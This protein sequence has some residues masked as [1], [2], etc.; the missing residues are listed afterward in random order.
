M[1]RKPDPRGLGHDAG[2]A[3][4][5]LPGSITVAG[6]GLTCEQSGIFLSGFAFFGIS[7]YILRT[8][9]V[10][11]LRCD[12]SL[13]RASASGPALGGF[14]CLRRRRRAL[15]RPAIGR[16]QMSPRACRKAL[17]PVSGEEDL[18]RRERLRLQPCSHLRLAKMAGDHHVGRESEVVRTRFH[19]MRVFALVLFLCL[20]TITATAQ[21]Q[22][23]YNPYT[24]QYNPYT[25]RY[26]YAPRGATPRYNPY[27]QQRELA[28]PGETLQ[29]NPYTKQRQY[30]PAGAMPR[31]NPYTKQQELVGPN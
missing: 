26:E 17:S 20:P 22:P 13:V 29:Y 5:S 31:Y 7:P 24:D 23:R 6:T 12:D 3:T 28:G 9:P 8:M 10:S 1:K 2:R 18:S 21:P 14:P 16:R 30:A 4:H 19:A 15:P 11:C 27:T 25:R